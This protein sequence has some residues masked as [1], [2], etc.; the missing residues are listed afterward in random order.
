MPVDSQGFLREHKDDTIEGMRDHYG[1]LQPIPE[2]VFR[3]CRTGPGRFNPSNPPP[4][5]EQC[6][7][8]GQ[9]IN[10]RYSMRQNYWQGR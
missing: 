8:D 1:I 10:G 9:F 2:C 5:A 3:N 6:A 7:P 4:S